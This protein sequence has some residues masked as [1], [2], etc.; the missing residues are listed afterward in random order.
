MSE[1]EKNT[2]PVRGLGLYGKLKIPVKTLDKI[3]VGG[4]AAIVIVLFLGLQ[5]RGYTVSF[6]SMGGTYVESQ[7]HMYGEPVDETD[8]PTR[9]GYS[10]TGW[11]IDQNCQYSWNMETDEVSESMTLYAGWQS[12]NE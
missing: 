10:F 8:N 7:R 5:N 12:K 1:S 4:I 11:Y 3:I 2:P 9:E 6:D